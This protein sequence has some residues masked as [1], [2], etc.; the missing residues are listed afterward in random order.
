MS[1]SVGSLQDASLD[2]DA[3]TT[4]ASLASIAAALSSAAGD[5]SVKTKLAG[6]VEQLTSLVTAAVRA[7]PEDSSQTGQKWSGVQPALRAAGGLLKAANAA[8]EPSR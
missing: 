5:A 8:S 6:L 3:V 2:L 1:F 7:G 4:V